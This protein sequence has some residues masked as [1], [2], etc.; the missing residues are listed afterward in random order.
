M[1][2]YDPR[3]DAYIEKSADFAKPVLTHIR[4]LAH[5]A[6]PEIRETIKFGMPHFDC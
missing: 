3:I 2:Q 1:E 4:K 5:L 6:Y